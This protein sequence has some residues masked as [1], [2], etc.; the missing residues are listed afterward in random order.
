[1][2]SDEEIKAAVDAVFQ[3]FDKD[4]NGYLDSREIGAMLS[5]GFNNIGTKK[6]ITPAEIA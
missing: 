5:A 6:K 2:S 4:N 1:M 3:S